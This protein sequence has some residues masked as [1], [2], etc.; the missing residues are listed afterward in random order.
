[1]KIALDKRFYKKLQGRFGKYDFRAGVLDDGPHYAARRGAKGKGGEDVTSSYAG[2]PI[3]KK[4]RTIDTTLS[5]VSKN[6]RED[7]GINYLQRPFENKNNADILKFSKSFF[8]L[9]FGRTQKRRAENLLQ[10][11]IRNPILRGEYNSQ[12]DLTTK[13]KGFDRPLIDTAQFFKSIIAKCKV[14]RSV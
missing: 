2:G 7:L 5:N 12:G 9:A 6:I 3:R 8:D 14:G 4:S 1:M 10:A 11:I 13:I